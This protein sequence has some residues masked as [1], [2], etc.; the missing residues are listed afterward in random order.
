MLVS[1]GFSYILTFNRWRHIL[2]SPVKL[3]YQNH[4]GSGGHGIYRW[5]RHQLAKQCNI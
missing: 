1:L 4:Y 2:L 5:T 3:C